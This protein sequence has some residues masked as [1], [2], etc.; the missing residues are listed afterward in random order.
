MAIKRFV[1]SSDTTITNAF[2]SNLRTRATASNM[3]QSDILEVFSI[4]G[5]ATGSNTSAS[6]E[7]SRALL[8]FPINTIS[9]SRED[10]NIP[11]SGSVNFYLRVFNAKHGQPVPKEYT[12]TVNAI[13]TD[14][15]E[16]RGLDMENYTDIDVCNWKNAKTS[17]AWRAI[18]GDYHTF[19]T[20]SDSSSSFDAYFSGGLEDLEVNI[21]TLVEQWINSH[22]NVLSSK[23]NYGVLLRLSSS[24]EGAFSSSVSA[25][26]HHTGHELHNP[27]GATTSYYTKKFFAR[28]TQFF[29]KRPIIEARWDSSTKDRRGS[30]YYSSSLAPAADNLNTLY[31][32]NYVRGQ[33]KD[34]PGVGKN[35][36]IYVSLYSGNLSNGAPAGVDYKLNL[37]VG[38]GTQ[39]AGDVNATGTW[40]DT[41]IYSCSVALTGDKSTIST[42]FDVWHAGANHYEHGTEYYTG[43]IKPIDFSSTNSL[44]FNP[45]SKYVSKITNLRSAYNNEETARFRLYTRLKDWS[46]TIYT[47]ASKEIETNT[48]EDVYYKV[49]RLEDDLSVVNYGT[50]SANHTRLSYD[51]SGSYFDLDMSMFEADSTYGIKFIYYLNGK[52]V[53]QPETFKFRVE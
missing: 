44:S 20:A 3:G 2:K 53:E 15:T 6:A 9:S 1:A 40:V 52:Y 41:G 35:E 18:G 31:L 32:Y 22:G 38:G 4:Y 17:A 33:L 19:A 16:G 49:Y 48:V 11:A 30:F 7:L 37:S 47:K 42:L 14:W 27:N 51:I 21:T 34:I 28:G 45:S 26:P 23:S 46:P 8:K 10:G 36:K 39:T 12:L 25:P 43:S 24:H 13:S 5:Q 50:G 29:Y